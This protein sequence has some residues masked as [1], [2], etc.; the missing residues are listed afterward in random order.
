MN[1]LYAGIMTKKVGWVVDADIRGYFDAI[2]HEWLMKFIAKKN[3][4]NAKIH[5]FPYRPIR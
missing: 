3:E 4:R 2:D 1:A 5:A